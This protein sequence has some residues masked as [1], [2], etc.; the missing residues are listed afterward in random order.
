[1]SPRPEEGPKHLWH[2]E[3]HERLANERLVFVLMG[4]D[5]YYNRE[6]AKADV[7]K[8]LSRLRI[9]SYALWELIGEYDVMLQAWLPKGVD[10]TTLQT[11]IADELVRLNVSMTTMSVDKF[12]H[13]WMWQIEPDFVNATRMVDSCHYRT[14]NGAAVRRISNAQIRSYMDAGLVASV[15]RY[16][17]I[18]FFVRITNPAR[19]TDEK[20]HG[21]LTE[22]A[23]DGLKDQRILSPVLMR[24]SGDAGSYLLTGRIAPREFEQISLALGKSLGQHGRLESLRCRTTT[25]I[26]AFHAPIDRREQLLPEEEEPSIEGPSVETLRSWLLQPEGDN[27]E[28]KSSAFRDVNKAVGKSLDRPARSEDEQVGEIAKAVC[29]MLNATGGHIVVG[30]AE[31]DR[32]SIEELRDSYG[33]VPVIGSR[34]VIGVDNEYP[35]RSGWDRFERKLREKVGKYLSTDNWFKFFPVRVED[36]T[37]CVIKVARPSKFFYF[38]VVEK[39]LAKSG[40][41]TDRVSE[42]FYGRA[43]GQTKPLQGQAMSEFM[44]AHPRTSRGERE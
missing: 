7:K 20:T 27:L 8:A 6:R 40:K 28:F 10:V 26:S 4:Y 1:M 39:V 42:V 29:G 21:E 5:P 18:K 11:T 44:E 33:S 32:Y 34:A 38:R 2:Y 19:G 16:N 14:L 17:T 31:L 24:V 23:L 12:V 22:R 15:P 25:H 36:Q 35:D 9:L 37:V 13:H 3:L 30:V 41:P 43:G